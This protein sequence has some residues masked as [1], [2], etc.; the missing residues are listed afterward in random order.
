MIKFSLDL[1]HQFSTCKYF[2]QRL[3]QGANTIEFFG[4]YQTEWAPDIA[5]IKVTW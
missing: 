4:G 3:R 2:S 1:I 5:E